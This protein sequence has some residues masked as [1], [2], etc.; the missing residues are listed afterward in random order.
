MGNRL[1]YGDNLKVLREHVADES[2][3]LIYLDPPFKSDQNYNVLF[4]E[5]NGT[6]SAAQ[7]RAFEDTWRWDQA[8]AAAY[9]ELVETGG[10]VSLVMQGFR[11][12]IGENDM[13][14]YLAM[15]A[16]R[17]V[18]LHRVLKPT[19]SIY[20][21]CDPTASHYLKMLLDAVSGPVNFRNEIVWL[22]TLSKGLMTRRLPKNHD[23]ILAYQKTEEAKWNEDAI[24]IRHDP[25]DLDPKTA[26][27]YSHRD[28]DGRLYRLDNLINP[29]PDRPNL[30]YEFLGVTK[31]WRWTKDR[32]QKAYDKGLVVQT[33]PAAVPQLK[34]YLDEQRG[35]PI[36]DVWTDIPP[37]NSQAAERLG[38]PTQKPERLLERILRDHG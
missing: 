35:R 6:R 23:V 32:M 15:M 20:L 30:K 26:R 8:A 4:G 21:H 5:Q 25:E 2:V 3:D 16:P 17:L 29:N 24:F 33:R 28:P 13:L 36:G 12:A 31:V 38:Y 34:R 1:Y 7:I 37:I 14:A 11:Q 9:Q 19:G 22:R 18:E 27:K 10:R